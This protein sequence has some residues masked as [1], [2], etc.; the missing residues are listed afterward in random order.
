[1][2]LATRKSLVD[3]QAEAGKPTL[4]RAL[5]PLNLTAL[6]I[7]SV[8]G[9]GIF[10]LT[11]TAASQNAGPAL[12]ISMII[13]AVACAFAGL[14]YAEL[15][16]FLRDLGIAFPPDLTVAPCWCGKPVPLACGL[17]ILLN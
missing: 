7:G 1:M 15:A 10:A 4:R 2:S 14:C 8:I 12:V 11:G 9:T 3:L 17:L 16:S 13:A 5:G 6:G